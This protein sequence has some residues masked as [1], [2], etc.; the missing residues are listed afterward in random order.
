MEQSLFKHHVGKI[1]ETALRNKEVLLDVF[2]DIEPAINKT[3]LNSIPRADRLPTKGKYKSLLSCGR[4][5]RSQSTRGS[6]QERTVLSTMEPGGGGQPH[7]GEIN[8]N[9][10]DMQMIHEQSKSVLI[11]IILNEAKVK[12]R[13][14]LEFLEEMIVLAGRERLTLYCVLRNHKKWT[15]ALNQLWWYQNNW[16]RI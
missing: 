2:F 1:L 9:H 6:P 7:Y 16:C 13:L 8:T 11:S 4:N 12:S 15:L 5:I 10:F 3:S 14:A